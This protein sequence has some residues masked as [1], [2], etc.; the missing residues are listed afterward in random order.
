MNKILI[1]NSYCKLIN[2]N[3][4]QISEITNL[5]SYKLD[6]Q[7]DKKKLIYKLKKAKKRPN[8]KQYYFLVSE[9][10]KL[11]SKEKV[12]WLKK[13]KYFPT[14]LLYK[15]KEYL[16]KEGIACEMMDLREKPS[17]SVPL[18]LINPFDPDRPYQTEMMDIGLKEGRGVF[19]SSVGSGKSLIMKRLCYELSVPTLI[20]VPAKGLLAQLKAD[21]EL[22]FGQTYIEQLTTAKIKKGD[23]LKPI[24]FVTVQT[25]ASLQKQGLVEKALE[26]IDCVFFEE[27][28]HTASDSYTQ[29]LPKMKDI[30]Y[31]FS[32]SGTYVRN[33]DRTLDLHAVLS[34]I[35]YEYT[36]QQ[37][38]QD[39]YLTPIKAQIYT[40]PSKAHKNYQIEYKNNY[41]GAPALLYKIKDIIEGNSTEDQ[42]LILVSRKDQGGKI[43]S[44]FLKQ[45][46]IAN[47]FISGDDKP[48]FISKCIKDFNDK[49]INILIGSSVIGEGINVRSTDH[50]IMAQGGKSEIAINQAVGRAVRLFEGKKIA[51]VHD[52]HFEETNYLRKHTAQRAKIYEKDFGAEVLYLT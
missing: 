13:E 41:C 38:I 11:L 48:E 49:K 12:C 28:H 10:K 35:L 20:I 45:H 17:S 7:Y 6:L 39:G 50:L 1:K 4:T 22:N 46:N 42:I 23:K 14:G 36:P 25:L 2:F 26:D 34:N 9:F 32:F 15:V 52:F 18:R 8:L 43:L 44:E 40:L 19:W 21:F 27:A 47:I 3:K 51:W 37:A 24:R 33:D 29:L 30:Y 31:R 16:K 5:L